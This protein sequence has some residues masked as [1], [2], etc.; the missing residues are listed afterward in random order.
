MGERKNIEGQGPAALRAGLD[1][2]AGFSCELEAN[3][4]GWQRSSAK[5][6]PGILPISLVID[7]TL[8]CPLGCLSCFKRLVTVMIITATPRRLREYGSC[9]RTIP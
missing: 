6:G 1:V 3:L 5:L 8:R 9:R 4:S 2:H 7:W